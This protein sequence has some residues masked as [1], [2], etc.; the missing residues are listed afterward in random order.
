MVADRRRPWL[1]V[2]GSLPAVPET[3]DLMNSVVTFAKLGGTGIN[4]KHNNML[5]KTLFT[6]LC[7]FLL[8]PPVS[9]DITVTTDN[10]EYRK[11][12]LKYLQGDTFI[13][14]GV[15]FKRVYIGQ[16]SADLVESMGKPIKVEKTSLLGG[17]REYVYQLDNETVLRVGLL[18]KRVQA[19]AVIGSFT[20]QYTTIKGARF[21]MAPHQV[22]SLYGSGAEDTDT[23]LYARIGIRFDFNSAQ[24]RVIRIFQPK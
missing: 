14:E 12:V 19:I 10:S 5:T 6:L 18:K 22:K 23:L 17:T 15:G 4:D 9:A 2:E 8:L 3:S 24:L 13:T 20:S 1:Q 7:Y 21:G 11:R 16:S